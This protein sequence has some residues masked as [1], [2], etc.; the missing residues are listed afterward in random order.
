MRGNCRAT[1]SLSLHEVNISGKVAMRRSDRPI[2]TAETELYWRQEAEHYSC[3]MQA[4]CHGGELETN[5]QFELL[6]CMV[7]LHK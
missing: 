7:Y 4:G 6:F 5:M 2:G 1:Y 3:K